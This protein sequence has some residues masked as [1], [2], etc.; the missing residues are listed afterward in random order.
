MDIRKNKNKN[1]NDKRRNIQK[2]VVIRKERISLRFIRVQKQSRRDAHPKSE[3]QRYWERK[4]LLVMN[5]P[6]YCAIN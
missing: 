2:L 5:E 4:L 1:K 6:V 3:F